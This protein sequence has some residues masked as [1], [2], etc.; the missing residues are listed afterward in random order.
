MKT[1]QQPSVKR[2]TVYQNQTNSLQSEALYKSST[3]SNKKAKHIAELL[4]KT[5]F[6][7]DGK[8]GRYA[9]YKTSPVNGSYLVLSI[10]R[11]NN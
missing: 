6:F 5:S 9:I 4:F 2:F 10:E 11:E 8:I 3:T 7:Y 1:T